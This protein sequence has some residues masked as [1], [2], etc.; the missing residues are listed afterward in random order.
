MFSYAK[1][2]WMVGIFI[3]IFKAQEDEISTLKET[4]TKLT[5]Q[6]EILEEELECR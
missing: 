5:T 1:F 2:K 3:D 6:I 4:L